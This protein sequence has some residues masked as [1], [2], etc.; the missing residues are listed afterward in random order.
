MQTFLPYKDFRESAICLDYRRLLNQPKE[1]LESLCILLNV[2]P[3][4]M[5]D[6]WW[7]RCQHHRNHPAVLMWKGYER[8][9]M[10]YGLTMCV[11]CVTRGYKNVY[12]HKILAMS[13]YMSKDLIMPPWL[14]NETFHI[15]HRS[16]LL[17][18]K[19]E[20]YKQFNWNVTD[21]LPYYWPSKEIVNG[22]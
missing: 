2:Q 19:P 12:Y 8:A 18:K 14:G 6:K 13:D 20:H 9:L 7:K 17:R 22:N 5:T 4:W 10:I 16:N 1:V 11:N 21:N 15:S 3:N